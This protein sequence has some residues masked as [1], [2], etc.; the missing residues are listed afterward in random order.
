[1]HDD[2][3]KNPLST[4]TPVMTV[5]AVLEWLDLEITYLKEKYNT[6]PSDAGKIIL[7]GIWLHLDVMKEQLTGHT[8]Q[9][10]DEDK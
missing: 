3:Y 4:A 1:M 10:L 8:L 5:A 9:R 6:E 7:M 2:H